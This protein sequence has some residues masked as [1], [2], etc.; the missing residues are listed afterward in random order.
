M[1]ARWFGAFAVLATWSAAG[2]SAQDM[3]FLDPNVAEARAGGN[4]FVLTPAEE[5]VAGDAPL[6]L[7]ENAAPAPG[8]AP[9]PRAQVGGS[10]YGN[11]VFDAGAVPNVFPNNLRVDIGFLYL[12][13]VFPDQSATLTVP[14]GVN[15]NF[16][17]VSA[18]GNPSFGFGFIPKFSLG[19]NF[20]DL[21]FGVAAS[22]VLLNLSG[23]LTRTI[24][25]SAGSANLTSSG[26]I[27]IAVAN[28]LEG[29]LPLVLGQLP[30][31]ENSCLRDTLIVGSLGARYSFVSQ[32]FI[33]SL[34]SGGNSSMIAA[35]QNW[36][37]FGITTSL[38]F[39][40]PLPR[41][42]F[43]YG[44]SRGSFLLGTNHRYSTQSVVV[45]GNAAASTSAKVLDNKTELI[46]VGEFEAGVAWG[47]LLSPRQAATQLAVPTGR[48]LWI[49]TGM[50]ADVWG[51]L[52]LLSASNG[53][54]GFANSPLV[55]W[56]FSVMA[57]IQF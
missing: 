26:T 16:G 12:R 38:N 23:Q 17:T 46:P 9:P 5:S 19:Y 39:L 29:T 10:V 2:A 37:G 24:D 48:I 54:N 45:S 18:S 20:S 15:G 13:P 52:G 27:N 31:F 28:L 21:G 56:G 1:Y 42:F 33:A 32:D 8:A 51:G 35:H 6:F 22:G 25:S 57:G 7:G 30:C 55:L 43:L 11:T 41:N 34:N 4:Q 40:H 47:R 44:T 36:Y 50:V 3:L 14:T 49:K 53:V